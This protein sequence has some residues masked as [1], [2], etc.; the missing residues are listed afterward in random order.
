MNESGIELIMEEA[1]NKIARAKKEIKIANYLM[2][3]MCLLAENM[4]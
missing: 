1:S 4:N 3:V 2:I